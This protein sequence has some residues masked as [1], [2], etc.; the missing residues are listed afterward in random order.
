M[1][2]NSLVCSSIQHAIVKSMIQHRFLYLMWQLYLDGV[3]KCQWSCI[4]FEHFQICS[5][6]WYLWL[7]TINLF[8]NLVFL[9]ALEHGFGLQE[10]STD[11]SSLS[12]IPL[13]YWPTAGNA[14]Q[15]RVKGGQ[16][17]AMRV[18]K[19]RLVPKIPAVKF[20]QSKKTSILVLKQN[21]FYH[22]TAGNSGTS[23]S[24]ETVC[25]SF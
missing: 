14:G 7:G 10:K 20:E 21:F 25:T 11:W 9:L 3:A 22:L 17:G 24:S 13:A 6:Q 19:L 16:C 1:Y 12:R 18:S 2:Y 5:F 4:T 15:C 23:G 8:N